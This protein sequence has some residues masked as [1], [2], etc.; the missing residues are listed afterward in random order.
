MSSF[1]QVLINII[2]EFSQENSRLDKIILNNLK[3]GNITSN[4]DY[5]MC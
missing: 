3:Y 1:F 4:G 5:K 2:I